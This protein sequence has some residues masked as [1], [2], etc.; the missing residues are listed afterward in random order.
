[1]SRCIAHVSLSGDWCLH[2]CSTS[3]CKMARS[4]LERR[5]YRY[6]FFF[7]ENLTLV[8]LFHPYNILLLHLYEI[9]FREM[10]NAAEWPGQ[11]ILHVDF[12]LRSHWPRKRTRVYAA[13][14]GCLSGKSDKVEQN[15]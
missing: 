10:L 2:I 4:C 12:A 5:K 8:K 7:K 6:N 14:F 3:R 15:I 1:M 13:Y 9:K 11:Y